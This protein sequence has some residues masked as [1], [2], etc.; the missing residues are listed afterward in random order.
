MNDLRSL[1][2]AQDAEPLL[3][4]APGPVA[5]LCQAPT[6]TLPSITEKEVLQVAD[7]ACRSVS[8]DS[9]RLPE[10]FRP[11]HLTVA[12]MEAVFHPRRTTASGSASAASEIARYCRRFGIERVRAVHWEVPEAADQET[13]G[14]LIRRY[15]ENGAQ[16]MADD[17][18]EVR[19]CGRG[20]NPAQVQ[21]VLDAARALHGIGVGVLQ[22]VQ[23]RHP[24]EI[25]TAL[26]R[27][28]G[29][30][31]ESVRLLLMF[32]GDDHFVRGDGVIRTFVASALGRRSVPASHAEE[33]VRRAAYELI[34]APRFLDYSLWRYGARGD[35]VAKPPQLEGPGPSFTR[36]TS[37][38]ARECVTEL[39]PATSSRE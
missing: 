21:Y 18:F 15:D 38:A 2:V 27:V 8:L 32:A 31:E 17:V 33:L 3:T 24:E 1:G 16:W 39:W 9:M 22:D 19:A 36:S 23:S 26:E 6:S 7:A 25:E 10:E 5:R 12:L 29:V 20:A 30:G 37:S 34:L 35:G 28:R 11:A 14:D 13:L 4:R